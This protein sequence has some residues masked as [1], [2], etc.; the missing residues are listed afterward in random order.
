MDLKQLAIL[1][2]IAETGSFNAAAGQLG[3]TQPA[4]SH[5]LRRLEDELGETLVLRRRPRATL[6]PA[7]ATVLAAAHRVL[8]EVDDLKQVFTPRE[9]SAVAGVLR[10]TASP[11]GI[12]YLY[13]ELI[14]SFIAR[15]QRIEVV[16]TATETP[17]DGARRVV[18][19]DADIAFVA[20]PI[21]EPNLAKL[22]LGEAE[23]A[24]L[25][26]QD[27]PLAGRAA[28]SP[29]EL[30]RYPMVRYKTGAGSRYTSDSIFL[31]RG[32]YPEIFLESNDTEFV[33][34]IVG[35]GFATAIVP[36]F[37]LTRDARDRRLR[38]LKIRDMTL[39][40]K[41]GIVYRADVRMR[42]LAAFTA[43]CARNKTMVPS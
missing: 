31:P 3:L 4:I 10:V 5:Q 42:A 7:G 15:H 37:V 38:L 22:V 30:K 14:A 25:V 35:L 1:R 32:G 27:H 40:Q 21:A 43:F 34:R 17:H 11:L 8:G 12:V 26:A 6:S 2:A 28:V 39:R 29:A 19:R 24:V 20:F 23:H 16:L 41:F 13:G 18:A 36:R 9:E 33:K